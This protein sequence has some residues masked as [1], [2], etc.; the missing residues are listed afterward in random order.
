MKS[1]T[2]GG[3]VI[4]ALLGMNVQAAGLPEKIELADSSM[5]L[6]A[7]GEFVMGSDKVDTQKRDT[8]FGSIKPWY[9]DEHPRQVKQNKDFYIDQYEVTNGQY[10]SFVLAT[11]RQP[12][13]HWMEDGYLVSMKRDKLAQLSVVK[14]RN[15]VVNTFQLDIDT[16]KMSKQALLEALDKHFTREDKIPV[17]NVNWFDAADY[18]KWAGKHLPTEA[19]WEEAARGRVGNEFPWG[20]DWEPGRANT[21]DEEWQFGAAPGGSYDKDK[22]SFSVFDMAGNVSEWV[23][24]WYDAYNQSDYQ[25]EK[26]GR[27]Y[28]V[29]RG[30]GW[31]GSG[32]YALEMYQR[33]AYRLYLSPDADHEDLG[34]RCAVEP[35]KSV[36][37]SASIK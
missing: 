19:Q 25:S 28:K 20:N 29:I 15:V 17:H 30:A 33:G 9:L 10:K 16:R 26:Y 3:V 23:S 31:G 21:G 5:V 24:D 7:A 36:L 1:R 37:K 22:S 18:C 35:S 14:L 2:T 12:P 13:S 27:Q 32:H 34:F 4:L 6:I 11:R 8:E